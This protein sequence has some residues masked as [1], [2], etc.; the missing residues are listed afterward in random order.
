MFKREDIKPALIRPGMYA[1][2]QGDRNYNDFVS[3]AI[4]AYLNAKND[5]ID[6]EEYTYEQ[7]SRDCD[8]W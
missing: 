6:M 1:G 5:M 2:P 4:A 8:R 7:F 3:D